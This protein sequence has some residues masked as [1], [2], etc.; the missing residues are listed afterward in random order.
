MAAGD[1]AA[2]FLVFGCISPSARRNR[3]FG[4]ISHTIFAC[5][6]VWLG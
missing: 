6:P 2:L 1:P 5:E 4:S 3:N